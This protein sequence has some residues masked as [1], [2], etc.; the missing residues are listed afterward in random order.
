LHSVNC[1]SC[2]IQCTCSFAYLGCSIQLNV[3]PLLLVV[4]RQFDARYT[5]HLLSNAAHVLLFTLCQL[6]SM[7]NPMILQICVFRLVYSFECISAAIA[8][9]T[10]TRCAFYSKFAPKYSADLPVFAMSTLV[11]AKSFVFPGLHIYAYVFNKLYLRCYWRY[12]DNSERVMLHICCQ[13]LRTCSCLHYVTAGRRQ[14]QCY[15]STA[16]SGFN[17]QLNVSPN[18]LE[19]CRHSLRDILLICS[20]TQRSCSCLHY[21]ISGRGQIQCCCCSHAYS[22]FNIQLH[23]STLLCVICRQFDVR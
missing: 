22:G 1:V 13:K 17:I 3:Y 16:C 20:Q 6:C 9:I 19:I 7:S 11:R 2:Q 15:C 23:V 14:I 12:V 10:A 21:V 18:P 8:D 4:W 5:P